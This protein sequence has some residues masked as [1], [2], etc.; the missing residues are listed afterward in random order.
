M[1][2]MVYTY[3]YK[4]NLLVPKPLI[5]TTFYISLGMIITHKDIAIQRTIPIS[6]LRNI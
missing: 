5:Y 6:I 2:A 4:K 1:H 3:M